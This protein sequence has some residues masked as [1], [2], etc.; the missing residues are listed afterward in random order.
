MMV[1]LLGAISVVPGM[2]RAEEYALQF[3]SESGCPSPNLVHT[4]TGESQ[5]GCLSTQSF[6]QVKSVAFADSS[7]DFVATIGQYS[8]C[9]LNFDIPTGEC[10][11]VDFTLRHAQVERA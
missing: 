4:Y 10:Y 5:S 7:G 1:A 3:F 2:V 6:G 8:D 9:S 11:D